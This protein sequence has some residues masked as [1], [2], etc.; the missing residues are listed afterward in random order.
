MSKILSDLYQLLKIIEGFIMV[1][2]NGG[3][4]VD[5]IIYSHV[6]FKYLFRLCNYRF[7]QLYLLYDLIQET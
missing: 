4:V 7:D 5:W 6:F 2:K 1:Y 3:I